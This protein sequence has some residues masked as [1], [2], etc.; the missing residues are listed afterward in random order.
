MKTDDLLAQAHE[1]EKKIEAAEGEARVALHA[2][3]HRILDDIRLH[4]GEV[5][6]H[7]RDLDLELTDEE[8]E[9]SFDNMPV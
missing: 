9:D 3:L 7:M 6:A 8:V 5:P 2:R 1:L 4:G